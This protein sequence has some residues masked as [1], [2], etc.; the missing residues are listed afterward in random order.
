MNSSWP[1][2][3]PASECTLM[4]FNERCRGLHADDSDVSVLLLETEGHL[5]K[6]QRSAAREEKGQRPASCE[7][8]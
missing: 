5:G 8:N 6:K 3:I 4:S 1:Y 7:P 2:L